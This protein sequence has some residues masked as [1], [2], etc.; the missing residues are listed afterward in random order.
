VD[1]AV[2]PFSARILFLAIVAIIGAAMGAGRHGTFL[3]ERCETLQGFFAK[4]DGGG[5]FFHI[6]FLMPKLCDPVA[7][8]I[9]PR[10]Y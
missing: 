5:D 6:G 10:R 3:Q 7:G 9:Y 1:T 2:L 8:E 4:G